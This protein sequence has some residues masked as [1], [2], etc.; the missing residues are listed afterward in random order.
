MT[1]IPMNLTTREAAAYLN[2]SEQTLRDWRSKKQGPRF[3][4]LGK[5]PKAAVRYRMR[6]LNA[7]EDAHEWKGDTLV[8]V[9]P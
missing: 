2:V 8:M 7:F 5:T 6:D 4:E 9:M 3:I 1:T